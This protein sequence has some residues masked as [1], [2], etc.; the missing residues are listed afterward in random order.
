MVLLTIISVL[1]LL[2][3]FYVLIVLSSV[4]VVVLQTG[5]FVGVLMLIWS[6]LMVECISKVLINNEF[7]H[8]MGCINVNV[9]C[10]YSFKDIFHLKGE[11][12]RDLVALWL[13]FKP[14]R[15]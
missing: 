3:S 11:C 14:S 2:E 1:M 10:S 13:T 12:D 4:S 8:R 5:I 7:Y 9:C 15:F 6:I